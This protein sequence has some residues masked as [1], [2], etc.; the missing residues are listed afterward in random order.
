MSDYTR[1]YVAG[2]TYFFT[3][4]TQL[5]RPVFLH[6]PIV[7][8]L[9]TCFRYVAAKRPFKVD[10]MVVLPDHLHCIWT[11]P[12]GDSDFSTRWRLAKRDFSYHY[13]D[14]HEPPASE[15][16]L[17]RREK[18]LWQRRFWEHAIRN[19]EDL[20]RHR[21]Y[22]HYNPVKHR[23]VESP[24]QWKHSTFNR[25][26]E[27]GLYDPDWGANVEKALEDMDLE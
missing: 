10:A 14:N 13:P 24:S 7:D 18:G 3:V 9:E 15:S 25:F 4:V 5:R 22:I 27:K 17:R 11:L 16:R 23:L 2:G 21:D 26:V 19:E 12:A 1:A 8:L 20:A 6:D